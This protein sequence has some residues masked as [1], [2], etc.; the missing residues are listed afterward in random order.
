[1]SPATQVYFSVTGTDTN[2][3]ASELRITRL[4]EKS[5]R[6]SVPYDTSQEQCSLIVNFIPLYYYDVFPFEFQKIGSLTNVNCDETVSDGTDFYAAISF[7][8]N[9]GYLGIGSCHFLIGDL[10]IEVVVYDSQT[11]YPRQLSMNQEVPISMA[12]ASSLRFLNLYDNPSFAAAV[13]IVQLSMFQFR[14]SVSRNATNTVATLGVG[15]LPL[16]STIGDFP[17]DFTQV[18]ELANV[19]CDEVLYNNFEFHAAIG[20]NFPQ[21]L[22]V[23]STTFNIGDVQVEVVVT[24]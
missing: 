17:F 16:P 12:P 3:F 15:F 11:A 23:G 7:D 10:D 2:Y 5:F 14:V 13:E 18:G 6:V 21:A 24:E 22:G 1:M 9:V 19:L 4:D 20:F 8:Y